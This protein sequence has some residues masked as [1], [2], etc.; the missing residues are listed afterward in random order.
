MLRAARFPVF[1]AHPASLFWACGHARSAARWT[2]L[3]RIQ[4]RF[5]SLAEVRKISGTTR[6]ARRHAGFQSEAVI[7]LQIRVTFLAD[8][9][10]RQAWLA[11]HSDVA[12]VTADLPLRANLSVLENIAVIPQYHDNQ[13][14]NAAADQAW[15]LLA[16]AGFTDCAF[17]RDPD[18]TH[19]ERFVAKLLR[20][21]I[22]RPAVLIIDRP[23]MLLPD[24]AYPAFVD[25]LLNK[26]ADHLN[27]CWIVDYRWNEPLYVHP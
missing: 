11:E 3:A 25:T 13:A 12:R 5:S 21:A 27:D 9:V 10:E 16:L 24:T 8:V 7:S 23:G 2:T 22:T 14:Y 26:L 6:Q 17:K 1:Q 19:E 18:L 20:A 4:L 15:A